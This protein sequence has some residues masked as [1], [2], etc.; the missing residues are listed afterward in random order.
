[1]KEINER[2]KSHINQHEQFYYADLASPL[3][4]VDGTPDD[5]LFLDDLL[6]LNEDGYAKW[7]VAIRPVLK[8]LMSE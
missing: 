8:E 5:S 3:L 6:H 4:A 7:N 1:M 2:I